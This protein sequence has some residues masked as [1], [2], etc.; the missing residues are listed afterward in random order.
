M[1][2]LAGPASTWPSF[3]PEPPC[4]RRSGG[5]SSPGSG[6]CSANRA[7]IPPFPSTGSGQAPLVGRDDG[8]GACGRRGRPG[9]H[10]MSCSVMIRRDGLSFS[11]A[12]PPRLRRSRAPPSIIDRPFCTPCFFAHRPLHSKPNRRPGPPQTAGRSRSQKTR[13]CSYNVL[14]PASSAFWR[15]LRSDSGPGGSPAK[16]EGSRRTRT[17]ADPPA[18]RRS[19]EMTGRDRG[20]LNPRKSGW[21]AAP[22][23]RCWSERC[24]P[25]RRRPRPGCS[26]RRAA[27]YSR[28][29]R[30]RSAGS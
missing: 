28:P 8:W 21:R 30:P 4:G 7:E 12:A 29:A 15:R 26:S 25:G 2:R 3:R 1:I 16:G 11:S 18:S 27:R 9:C 13:F 24:R 17:N 20:T 14:V 23:G 22:S 5:I 10:E 6:A 19:V